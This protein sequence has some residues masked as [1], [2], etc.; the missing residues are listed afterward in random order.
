MNTKTR[1]QYQA[2]ILGDAKMQRD[3]EL[4]IRVVGAAA[5]VAEVAAFGLLIAWELLGLGSPI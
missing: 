4:A 2:E 1:E 3:A 5:V